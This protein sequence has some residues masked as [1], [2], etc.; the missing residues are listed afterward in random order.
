MLDSNG[1]SAINSVNVW[2]SFAGTSYFTLL[3]QTKT[4]GA[5]KDSFSFLVSQTGY[6]VADLS[7][8]YPETALVSCFGSA[9]TSGQY[10]CQCV[11]IVKVA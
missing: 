4:S 8:P 3:G 1:S 6:T 2:P 10:W 9:W 11:S 5:F 7:V